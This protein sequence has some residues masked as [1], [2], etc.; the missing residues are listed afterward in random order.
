MTEPKVGPCPRCKSTGTILVHY[1]E[2][3]CECCGQVVPEHDKDVDCYDCYGKGH[4][5]ENDCRR[6]GI[7]RHAAKM[8]LNMALPYSYFMEHLDQED[9]KR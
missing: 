2:D 3:V 8:M 7:D 9:T 5:N 6:V 4:L 1:D